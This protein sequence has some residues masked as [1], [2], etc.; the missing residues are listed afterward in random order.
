MKKIIYIVSALVLMAG[1]TSCIGDLDQYP[2]STYTANDVFTSAD[3]YQQVLGGI[4]AAFIQRI[5]SV[6][7]EARSQ[8]YLRT[9]IMFQ[10]CSTD[11][12]DPIWLSGETLTDVN[13][14]A[15]TAS[16]PWCSAM[17]YHIYNIVAMCNDFIRNASDE[18]LLSRL[19]EAGRARVEKYRAEARFLRAYAYSHAIDFYNRMP[20]VTENDGVGAYI[21]VTYDRK[22][23]LDFL[24]AELTGIAE[25]LDVTSYGHAT[26]GAAYALLARLCLNAGTWTGEDRYTECISA[27][28]EVF[29]DGYTLESDYRKLFNGDN[30]LRAMGGSEI[31]FAFA[32]DG[33]K[34]TTWDATT[35]LVC[36][37]VL[38]GFADAVNIWGNDGANAWNNLRARPQLVDVFEYGDTRNLILDYNRES[39]GDGT[40]TE[41]QRSKDITAHDDATTGYRICKW[42]NVTD[43]GKAA[44]FCGDG[45]GANTDFPV[46]RLADVYLMLAEAVVRGGSGA[47]RAEALGYVNAVRERAFGSAAG[48][49]GDDDLDLDF[50]CDERLR[51][52]YLECIRRTDLIRFDRYTSGYNW[53]WKAN[54]Q[55]GADVDSRFRFLAIP[56]AEYS[57]NPGTQTINNEL[58]F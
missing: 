22:Q 32:C 27:C 56:E 14:L 1:S 34:T 54:T 45:G 18:N 15:W 46:F 40:Y 12:C 57:V 35:F 5:S 23:M 8:N 38:D 21:P 31:I 55:D 26:R 41:T 11:S 19:D 29:K 33:T 50:L 16:N 7:T 52:F 24:T 37:Q 4:Y 39:D 42:T 28:K 9:L 43:D 2:H 13:G 53:Q 17:Y 47:T 10:D 48:N 36:G 25:T 6:S 20:F 51:E 49:I 3:G 44:S 30:H 58:G